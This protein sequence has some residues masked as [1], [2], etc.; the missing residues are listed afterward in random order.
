LNRGI[1]L[2]MAQIGAPRLGLGCARGVGRTVTGSA[3]LVR[4]GLGELTGGF[5]AL[6][7]PFAS[8]AVAR[9]RASGLG[10]GCTRRMGCTR[11]ISR[12]V[13]V[14]T[15]RVRPGLGD[16]TGGFGT[17]AGPLASLAVSRIRA[18]SLGLGCTRRMG[19]TRSVGRTVTVGTV[20]VR[21]GLGDLTGGFGALAGRLTSLAVAGL[22]ASGL[23]LR[24][25]RRMGCARTVGRA[26]T[27]S[28]V[29]VR[30]R[31]TLALARRIR[32]R[33]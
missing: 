10:L 13:T 25:L 15:V 4:P 32:I 30:F 33:S 26:V 27:G 23:G 6:A 19:C 18:S 2:R 16:L 24:C 22:R 14:G 5:G 20:R 3:M 28:T 7:R 29:R 11:S 31:A 9:I 17:L 12:A 8:L 21:P 1:R